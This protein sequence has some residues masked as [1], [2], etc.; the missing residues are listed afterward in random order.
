MSVDSLTDHFAAL[1]VP[2]RPWLDADELKGRFLTITA[3]GH[4]DI[5]GDP[6]V[7][8]AVNVAYTTL[9]QPGA[10]LRH[11][12][13]LEFPDTL[14]TSVA[15]IPEAL[16]KCFMEIATLRREAGTFI[17]QQASA[18]GPLARAL[19]VSERSMLHHDL[20]K[21]A[22]Q[23]TEMHEK[24]LEAIQEADGLWKEHPAQTAPRLAEIQQEL[25]YL[26]KWSTQLRELLLELE[27]SASSPDIAG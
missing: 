22:E 21:A 7:F 6:A 3:S 14:R 13:E 23:L 27:S 26:E 8:A 5:G 15:A 11:L 9:R 1:G 2:R 12:L 19:L 18:S 25:S 4:P 17:K 10:R 16:S 24:C 20:Q